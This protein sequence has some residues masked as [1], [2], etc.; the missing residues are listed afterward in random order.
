MTPSY[1]GDDGGFTISSLN[2]CF[3]FCILSIRYSFE[4]IVQMMAISKNNLGDIC[5]FI[6]VRSVARVNVIHWIV[7]TVEMFIMHLLYAYA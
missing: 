6:F 4:K 1:I 7:V 2:C 3:S 5:L